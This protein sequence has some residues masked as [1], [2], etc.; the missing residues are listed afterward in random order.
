MHTILLSL[1]AMVSAQASVEA[2]GSRGTAVEPLGRPL[3]DVEV[4]LVELDV[5]TRTHE[6]GGFQ[7]VRILPAPKRGR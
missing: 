1:I 3:H 2:E 6:P 4:I 7:I 5:R